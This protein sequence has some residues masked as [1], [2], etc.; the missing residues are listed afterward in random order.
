MREQIGN[1]K[2]HDRAKCSHGHEL[3]K[4]APFDRIAEHSTHAMPKLPLEVRNGLV[5]AL[6][7]RVLGAPTE[8]LKRPCDVGLAPLRI[9]FG[10]G[11]RNERNAR[12][13]PHDAVDRLRKLDQRHL[14]RISDI[15]GQVLVGEQEAVDPLDQ[16]VHVAEGACLHSIAVDRKRLARAVPASADSAAPVHHSSPFVVRRC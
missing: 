2:V 3:Q 9:A 16:V 11:V 6:L 10:T 13:V 5:Q 1:A 4:S 14:I 8:L 12:P 7:Q 15:H